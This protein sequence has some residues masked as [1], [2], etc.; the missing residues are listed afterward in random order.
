MSFAQTITESWAGGGNLSAAVAKTGSGRISVDESIATGASDT[1]IA[2]ML[3]F[4]EI[5]VLYILSDQDITL[6]TNSG[7]APDDTF[8]LLA[9]EPL[10][11][12]STC[13][14]SCPITVDITALFVT[15]ASGST[16]RLRV[17]ALYDATP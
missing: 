4:S 10:V 1:Q 9:N 3:D 15:N 11:W 2:F 12:W 6:E 13:L 17:E 16:A 7:A 8:S 14:H 5:E